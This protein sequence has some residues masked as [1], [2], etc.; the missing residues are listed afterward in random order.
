MEFELC[1]FHQEASIFNLCFILLQSS[2]KLTYVKN[3]IF[4]ITVR[5]HTKSITTL[6]TYVS[7]SDSLSS[8]LLLDIF[9][10]IFARCLKMADQFNLSTQN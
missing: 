9:K 6:K 4:C 5:I 3:A 2:N 10:C 1:L 7:K 8:T